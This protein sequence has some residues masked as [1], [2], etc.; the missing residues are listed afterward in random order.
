MVKI[1][2]LKAGS[3][4]G[5][6]ANPIYVP[7]SYALPS[8]VAL[9][10]QVSGK[11]YF[12]MYNK[13][14]R[15][16]TS[17]AS[18]Y[19]AAGFGL[20]G[21]GV[22]MMQIGST[23]Y[24][25]MGSNRG[26]AN[27]YFIVYSAT[28]DGSFSLEFTNGAGSGHGLNPINF[29][30]LGS[31]YFVHAD[32]SIAKYVPSTSITNIITFGCGP[33][34]S[35]RPG[36]VYN[37]LYYFVKADTNYKVYSFNGTAESLVYDTG[38]SV[39]SG[40]VYQLITYFENMI[41]KPIVQIILYDRIL[42]YDITNNIVVRT[43]T[44]PET[45]VWYNIGIS[46]NE[47]PIAHSIVLAGILYSITPIGLINRCNNV[48]YSTEPYVLMYDKCI[49]SFIAGESSRYVTD[50]LGTNIFYAGVDDTFTVKD[51]LLTSQ[52]L[53][54]DKITFTE[55]SGTPIL[56]NEVHRLYL[57]DDTTKLGDFI[58]N[59]LAEDVVI[60]YNNRISGVQL[61]LDRVINVNFSSLTTVQ[62]IQY[63]I[64]TETGYMWEN[65]AATGSTWSL[66]LNNKSIRELFKIFQ[67]KEK[68]LIRIART[69]EVIFTAVAS[70]PATGLT[71]DDSNILELS[72]EK[73]NI[74]LSEVHLIGIGITSD[75][76]T[77]TIQNKCSLYDYYP[78]SDQTTLDAIAQSILDTKSQTITTL[79]VKVNT[80]SYFREYGQS[81][82]VNSTFY[83]IASST[84]YITKCAI[85]DDDTVMFE[86]QD[87]VIF[88]NE[89]TISDAEP[90][91]RIEAK[92]D[93]ALG[94]IEESLITSGTKTQ[95]LYLK[96]NE[97]SA[98]DITEGSNSYLK[99]VTTNSGEKIVVG[100][101]IDFADEKGISATHDAIVNAASSHSVKLQ[102]NA[103]DKLV[104][105]GTTI[106]CK[107]Q[108][109][110]NVACNY[111][112]AERSKV[113]NTS[114][115]SNW[116]S[117][118]YGDTENGLLEVSIT[119]TGGPVFIN[120]C[121][122]FNTGGSGTTAWGRA[123]IFRD[124]TNLGN[125]DFGMQIAEGNAASEND[126]WNFA[127]LD[128]GVVGSPGTYTYKCK[129]RCGGGTVQ[130]CEGPQKAQIAVIE[131]R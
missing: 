96:D 89:R 63:I 38:I 87:V 67:N 53:Q 62:M 64:W 40:K 41:D 84:W 12:H 37:G 126:P 130:V 58:N 71:L 124:S 50:Y 75:K 120:C 66:T 10:D 74:S 61:D 3:I 86:L 115:T 97:A 80:S 42:V 90:L 121:I 4:G 103:A 20:A 117:V 9:T 82:T 110:K 48:K 112:V 94:K 60:S 23:L 6:V 111:A 28:E 100:K 43:I 128:T 32:R 5:S 8:F 45:T 92:A 68:K 49:F 47:Q 106:D 44:L 11:T 15:Y 26:G 129:V 72:S 52:Q 99:F 56:Q 88:Q 77:T 104:L 65:L 70:L 78:I 30:K 25:L 131:M 54:G 81:I 14:V 93:S 22:A 55:E 127:F 116:L 46:T 122:N 19:T 36:I 109:L 24:S 2:N 59:T 39:V 101:N 33:T 7:V 57:D 91:T 98:L 21:D 102:V 18:T 79:Y 123:T 27:D 107:S 34:A 118:G 29:F 85:Q 51:Y 95:N 73:K 69:G 1:K 76:Y 108:K 114:D 16:I 113:W 17:G 83:D 31:D 13:G 35:S 105:D 119:T 125:S